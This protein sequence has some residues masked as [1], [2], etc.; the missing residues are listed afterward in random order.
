[1][2]TTRRASL[3]HTSGDTKMLLSL[4]LPTPSA[5]SSC[6]TINTLLPAGKLCSS[7]LQAFTG[8]TVC[9]L[10][11]ACLHIC[12]C[13]WCI[14][15]LLSNV[16]LCA[17]TASCC[18]ATG[19]ARMAQVWM[20]GLTMASLV[21]SPPQLTKRTCT[22][23]S[24]SGRPCAKTKPAAAAVSVGPTLAQRT[25]RHAGR[26]CMWNVACFASVV[27]QQPPSSCR[28]SGTPSVELVP[29]F[30]KLCVLSPSQPRVH[31]CCC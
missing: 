24:S 4:L 30:A 9:W 15:R 16:L 19:L 21:S 27:H 3:T 20:T 10:V 17:L 5:S 29:V 12:S 6:A 26:C 7:G 14:C 11:C 2:A 18:A 25:N 23:T 1:M 22:G 28:L 13:S 31:T 8:G